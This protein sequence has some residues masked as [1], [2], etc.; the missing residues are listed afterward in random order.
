[1]T[2]TQSPEPLEKILEE[3]EDLREPYLLTSSSPCLRAQA[4]FSSGV[5]RPWLDRTS[6]TVMPFADFDGKASV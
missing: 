1:M 4:A 2:I 5:F 6:G 3:V